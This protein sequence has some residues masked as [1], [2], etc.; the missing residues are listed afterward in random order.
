MSDRDLES[1]KL[2]D[3][4]PDGKRTIGMLASEAE[5][6]RIDHA[7]AEVGRQRRKPMARSEFMLIAVLR[8]TDDVLEA[9]EP[10]PSTMPAA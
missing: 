8:M 2:S 6:A 4:A 9:S 10:E 3:G 5:I 7:A 1:V